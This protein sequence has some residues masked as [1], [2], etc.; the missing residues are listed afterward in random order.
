[1]FLIF[2]VLQS[3]NLFHAVNFNARINIHLGSAIDS[4]FIDHSRVYSFEVSSLLNSLSD[5]DA[6]YLI[7][8]NIFILN[9]SSKSTYRTRLI[10]KETTTNVSNML[11]NESWQANY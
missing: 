4:T 8:N 7:L 1:V 5:H 2:A 9:K 11:K 6:K 3:Y 10:I